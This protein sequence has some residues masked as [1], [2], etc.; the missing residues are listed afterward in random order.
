MKSTL[1]ALM[2]A[3]LPFAP[4]AAETP[5][6]AGAFEA[7]VTGETLAFSI[8]DFLLGVEEYSP[9]REVRWSVPGE[10]CK[11]GRWYP[12]G[13]QICFVYLDGTGPQ[14]W[15]FFRAPGGL[16]AR[17]ADDPPGTARYDV[18]ASDAPMQCLGPEIG[19]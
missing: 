3:T 6:S 8:G 18:R 16:R 14:C 4:A 2:V 19:V 11:T 7:Y 17:F 10:T 1:A 9:G 12:S 15:T 5:M 13:E